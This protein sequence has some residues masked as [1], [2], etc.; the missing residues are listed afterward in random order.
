MK[1]HNREK[2]DTIFYY[3]KSDTGAPLRRNTGENMDT[4]LCAG[5]GYL[6]GTFNPSYLIGRIKGVD[7]RRHGSGNAGATNATLIMGKAIGL[8]CALLDI[9]K[10]YTAYKLARA[11]FPLLT[12]A[13]ALAGCACIV[14]HIFPVWMG[15][16]GGK[17]LACIGGVILAHNW[18]L[19]LALLLAEILLTLLVG[20]ICVMALSVSVIF[21]VIYGVTTRDLT[22]A[23]ILSALIPVV[24]YKHMPNIR[25]I[26]EG[27]EARI[28][29]LWNAEK[30]EAR[31]QKLYTDD[32]WNEIYK[33]TY[34]KK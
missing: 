10:A 8:L 22:G 23:L 30:E 12:F 5:M 29:W 6:I 24:Y 4:V 20:Y 7:I 33:K 21:P 16:A 13:G 19:F 25:R 26:I 14:G 1:L 11:L 17:G 3:D 18:K 27:R 15:F 9:F 34:E 2:C 28:S 32:E 31:L